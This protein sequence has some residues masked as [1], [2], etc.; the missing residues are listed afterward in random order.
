MNPTPVMLCAAAALALYAM[1]QNDGAEEGG[2][3][4]TITNTFDN[5][6]TDDMSALQNPNVQAFM[7]LIRTCEGT[8]NERGYNT[9]FGYKYFDSFADHPRLKVT[10]NGYTS[11]AAGAYQIVAGTWDSVRGS[12]PDFS[13]ASQDV[14]AVRLIKRR[15]ALADVIAGRIQAAIDKCGNEWASLPSST[16]GQP[17]ATWERAFNIYARWG[18]TTEQTA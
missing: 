17:K 1:S 10:A 12:L 18:G 4:E 3:V 15:G 5:W 14:A 13:P 2:I 16:S 9:I 7:M 11:S 6:I 8:A